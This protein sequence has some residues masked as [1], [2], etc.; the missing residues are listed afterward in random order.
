M[1]HSSFTLNGSSYRTSF[2]TACLA[3]PVMLHIRSKLEPYG[4]DVIFPFTKAEASE[5]GIKAGDIL[6]LRPSGQ[7]EGDGSPVL[8]IEVLQR[9]RRK[10]QRMRRRNA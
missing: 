3:H 8:L 1:P 2:L 4:K 6:R 5:L 9:V 7:G 10:R